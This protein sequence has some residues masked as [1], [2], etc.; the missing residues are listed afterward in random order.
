MSKRSGFTPEERAPTIHCIEGWV[1]S[2]AAL[3]AVVKRR[4]F[5]P[6]PGIELRLSSL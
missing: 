1:N 5:Q 3:A 4:K 6:L 2:R